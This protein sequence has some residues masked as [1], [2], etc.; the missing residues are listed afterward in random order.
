MIVLFHNQAASIF[1]GGSVG[2]EQCIVSE[3]EF[4]ASESMAVS[5]IR[6]VR[7]DT[8]N[9]RAQQGRYVQHVWQLMFCYTE[10]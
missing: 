5:T 10:L 4:L 3:E 2:N 9:G 7:D 6:S 8:S 1:G